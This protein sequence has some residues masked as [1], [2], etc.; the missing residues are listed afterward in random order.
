M[1]KIFT[2]LNKSK[3][4][5]FIVEKYKS[6][7]QK[8]RSYYKEIFISF[9]IIIIN[10]NLYASGAY[11]KGTATGK[12]R[13]ELS[14]TYDP[15]GL[16]PYGQNYAVLSYGISKNSDIVTYYSKHQNGTRSQ[17]IGGFYQ[18]FNNAKI[19]LA[20]AVGLRYTNNKNLDIFCP[21]LLYNYKLPYGF[22]IGGSVVKVVDI[23]NQID[24]GSAI[25]ITLYSPIKYFKKINKNLDEV[26]FGVGLFKNT[27]TNIYRDK[28]YLHYSIDFIFGV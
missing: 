3:F 8:N 20:T 16:V 11:D 13:F 21:Q 14:I 22:S 4:F 18:F 9:W 15:I 24:R 19:D 23:K 27:E 5:I 28:L 26:Y 1:E 10:Q 25:D 12:N 2:N 6:I 17:Y 7:F